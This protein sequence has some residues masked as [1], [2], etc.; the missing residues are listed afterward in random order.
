MQV[1][2]VSI[3]GPLTGEPSGHEVR[4]KALLGTPPRPGQRA[5]C[6]Q[7]GR[8]GLCREGLGSSEGLPLKSALQPRGGVDLQKWENLG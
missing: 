3:L 1:G 5:S 6:H 2:T 8:R 4:E 7:L